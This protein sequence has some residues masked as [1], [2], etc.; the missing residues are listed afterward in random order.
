MSRVTNCF[1]QATYHISRVKYHISH[2]TYE[3]CCQ[4]VTV[5]GAPSM[6]NLVVGPE[7]DTAGSVPDCCKRPR[8]SCKASQLR[9]T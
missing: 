3:K 2:M 9:A 4:R 8:V 1:D 5:G 7:K 6:E